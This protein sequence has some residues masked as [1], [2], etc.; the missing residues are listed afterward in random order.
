MHKLVKYIFAVLRDQ[1]EY[2]QRSPKLH[3]KIHLEN[4]NNPAA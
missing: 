3:H 2:E 1:E 4:C